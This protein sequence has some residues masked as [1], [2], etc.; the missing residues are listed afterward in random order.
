MKPHLLSIALWFLLVASCGKEPVSWAEIGVRNEEIPIRIEPLL[1]RVTG[2][3]FDIGDRIGLTISTD[4]GT[5]IEN[6]NLVYDGS[7]FGAE[8]FIWYNNINLTADLIAYY[9]YA[10]AGVPTSFSVAADQ[11]G[12]GFATSDL[13]AAVSR[14]V[15]PSPLPVEMLFSHLMSK[16][17]I[18]INNSS[19]GAI[20][21]LRLA[22]SKLAAT[23]DLARKSA[24]VLSG[25]TAS[26][27]IPH[28]AGEID[29]YEAI[30]VP[31]Q[32]AFVL[33]VVTDDGKTHTCNLTT[34]SLLAGKIY[35]IELTLTNIDFRA[36]LQAE[37]EDWVSG[38]TIPEAG[39]PNEDNSDKNPFQGEESAITVTHGGVTYATATL[40]DGRCWMVENLRYNPTSGTTLAEGVYL[41]GEGLASTTDLAQY[42]LLYTAAAA[43]GVETIT[44]ENSASLEGA[45][46]LC[47]AGWHIPTEA[48][49]EALFAAYPEELPA[50][51]NFATPSYWNGLTSAYVSYTSKGALLRTSTPT[52]NKSTA[53][54]QVMMLYSDSRPGIKNQSNGNAYPVRCIKNR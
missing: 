11:S 22:G 3:T 35:T 53:D 6:K 13:L 47:P 18:E 29:C 17:R 9:P 5:Y 27:I 34:T 51:F 8:G 2:T 16:I 50:S 36:T 31:Q 33:T 32:V 44:S 10:A 21:N 4:E 45:Q 37:I 42:G 15:K 12:A 24:T 54:M 43:L 14:Q 40:A 30:V 7:V 49:A 1:T 46:G 38:G 41:P 25:A 23:I 20:T 39:N 26:S 28:P 19:D 52:P 48:E